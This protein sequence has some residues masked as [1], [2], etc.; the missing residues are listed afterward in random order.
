MS[1]VY[2]KNKRVPSYAWEVGRVYYVE[3]GIW[4][5]RVEYV[6]A[7]P[8]GK[9]IKHIFTFGSSVNWE[10]QFNLIDTKSHFKVYEVALL[11]NGDITSS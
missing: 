6:G 4:K 7:L 9:R 1:K 5:G 3:C 10:S 8:V 11:D 2:V